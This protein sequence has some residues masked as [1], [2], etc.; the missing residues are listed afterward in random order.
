MIKYACAVLTSQQEKVL[1]YRFVRKRCLWSIYKLIFSYIKM[2]FK[3]S[4]KYINV[5]V[6]FTD[7]FNE[8]LV[9][10][11]NAILLYNPEKNYKL[12]SFA[13]LWVNFTILNYVK[14]RIAIVNRNVVY[15]LEDDKTNDFEKIKSLQNNMICMDFS[16]INSYEKY[17]KFHKLKRAICNLLPILQIIIF[18]NYIFCRSLSL[19]ELGFF[20]NVSMETVRRLRKNT[21][22]VLYILSV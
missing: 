10:L 18:R 20:L 12:M 1:I 9:G 2:V 11:I 8:G 22:N 5:N 21:L 14:R 16:Y 13:F 17:Y 7:I 15:Y 4:Y 6:N 3:I 19:K